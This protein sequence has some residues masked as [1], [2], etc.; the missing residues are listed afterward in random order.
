MKPESIVYFLNAFW[1]ICVITFLLLLYKTISKRRIVV[2]V[3]SLAIWFVLS[4]GML[5]MHIITGIGVAHSSPNQIVETKGIINIIGL[6]LGY[7]LIG[8]YLVYWVGKRKL[9]LH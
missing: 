1:I 2:G 6:H 3:S 8:F 9:K 5:F 7:L 4:L